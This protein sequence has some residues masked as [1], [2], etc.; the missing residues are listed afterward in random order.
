MQ[1][2]KLI[3]SLIVAVVVSFCSMSSSKASIIPQFS[4]SDHLVVQEEPPPYGMVFDNFF[5]GVC[6]CDGGFASFPVA[7]LVLTVTNN[8]GNLEL[9]INSIVHGGEDL[10]DAYGFSGATTSWTLPTG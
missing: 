5:F 4:L 2:A 9:N 7:N 8:T 6:R 3:H 1:F 10:G